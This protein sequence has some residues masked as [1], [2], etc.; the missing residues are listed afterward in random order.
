MGYRAGK[1]K[2]S[3]NRRRS[4]TRITEDVRERLNSDKDLAASD[5][6]TDVTN[7][8]V[9]LS[10]TVQSKKDKPHAETIAETVQGV[11]EVE[12]SIQPEGGGMAHAVSK[13]AI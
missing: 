7:G 11:T 3:K 10:G 4:D 13:I 6:K 5:I 8:K 1:G 12:N 9:T 2:A